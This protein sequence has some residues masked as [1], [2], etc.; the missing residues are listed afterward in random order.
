VAQS[1]V[2]A[3]FAQSRQVFSL[4]PEIKNRAKPNEKGSTRV[5]EGVGVQALEVGR[6]GGQQRSLLVGAL[7]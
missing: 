1:L 2:D 3:V 6:P 4:P 5:Y 7:S